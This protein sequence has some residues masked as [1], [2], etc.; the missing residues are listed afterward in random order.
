MSGQL[1]VFSFQFSAGAALDAEGV[2]LTTAGCS[3]FADR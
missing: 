1:S 3:L 2:S